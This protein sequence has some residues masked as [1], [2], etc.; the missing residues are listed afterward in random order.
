MNSLWRRYDDWL[1]T[2]LLTILKRALALF[3]KRFLKHS[4]V[5]LFF[6]NKKVEDSSGA[7]GLK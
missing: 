2:E 1:V 6:L 3:N 7:V 5:D 4:F